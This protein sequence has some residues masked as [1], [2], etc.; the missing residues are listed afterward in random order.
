VENGERI[1]VTGGSGFI[2]TN[3][4]D[5]LARTSPLA[6]CNFDARPPRDKSQGG[7]WLAGDLC[8][9]GDIRHCIETFRPTTVVHLAARTDLNGR[10]MTEYKANTDGVEN[11]LRALDLAV[12]AARVIFASSRLVCPV[13]YEPRSDVEFDPTTF[14]GESKAVGEQ[15]VR[16][17]F[18]GR[19]D[20]WTIVRP[21]SIW[22]PWFGTPYRDFFES[23]RRGLYVHP[24]NV[25]VWKSFGFVGNTS[26]QLVR[27][28]QASNNSVCGAVLYLADY[29]PVEVGSFAQRIQFEM[30]APRV[31]SVRPWILRGLALIGD[32]LTHVGW[33]DPP[34]TTFR[35]NNLMTH[36]TYDLSR[37]ERIV[38]PLPFN[39]HAGIR[40]TVK[41]MQTHR[42]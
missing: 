20:T 40:E 36:M 10:S 33:S 1:L 4:I 25:E 9:Y 13:G 24:Q 17:H 42:L 26:F 12:P 34:L 31:R 16:R 6:L 27:I 19:E 7:M 35:L 29:T 8:N 2:G 21:T 14:Y 3:V 39:V 5:L 37:L 18:N 32:V 30:G 28:S 11:L 38:G 22:G 41:W 15:L 23:I